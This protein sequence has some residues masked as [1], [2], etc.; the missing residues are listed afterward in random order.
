[1][2]FAIALSVI[3]VSLFALIIVMTNRRKT[4]GRNSDSPTEPSAFTTIDDRSDR[5]DL[6]GSDSQGDTGSSD[7]GG[8]GGGDS[9]G[10][11]SGGGGD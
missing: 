1:M 11:D 6:Q 3:L 8:D 7:S 9:G 2:V 5:A 10:G 4:P